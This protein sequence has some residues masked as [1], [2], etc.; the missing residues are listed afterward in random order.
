MNSHPQL[1][2]STILS[3]NVEE[4]E[5]MFLPKDTQDFKVSNPLQGKYVLR[6]DWRDISNFLEKYPLLCSVLVDVH[7]NLMKYFPNN[8]SVFLSLG[9][10]PEDMSVDHLIASVASGLDVDAALDALSAFDK[11]WWLAWLRQTKG[12]LSITL[13]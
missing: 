10:A 13:E 11:E 5:I 1:A 9:I 12:K 3:D 4:D 8:P 7:R 6:D 2:R